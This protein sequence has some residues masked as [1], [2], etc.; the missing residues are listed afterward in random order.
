MDIEKIL[1]EFDDNKGVSLT[2]INSERSDEIYN[3][4]E[5]ISYETSYKEAIRK[6]LHV[7]ISYLLPKQREIFFDKLGKEPIIKLI[8][9]LAV[10]PFPLC[11][12]KLV[13]SSLRKI[14]VLDIIKSFMRRE[15]L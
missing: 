9:R 2:M 11:T 3:S 8:N 7:E 4:V 6:N 13:A 14:V 10:D 1:P 15:T 5:K 12:R